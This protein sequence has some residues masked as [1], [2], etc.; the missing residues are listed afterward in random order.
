MVMLW[1]E[2]PSV[3]VDHLEVISQELITFHVFKLTLKIPNKCETLCLQKL[4][5]LTETE[6]FASVEFFTIKKI[7]WLDRAISN[8]FNERSLNHIINDFLQEINLLICLTDCECTLHKNH[9]GDREWN[10]AISCFMLI[11]ETVNYPHQGRCPVKTVELSCKFL[12]LR[13]FIVEHPNTSWW[14]CIKALFDHNWG[15]APKC[16]AI[17]IA[18][19]CLFECPIL[20]FCLCI[21]HQSQHQQTR[22]IS[23]GIKCT[24][25][26]D[27]FSKCNVGCWIHCALDRYTVDYWNSN[28]IRTK[29]VDINSR[30]I[31]IVFTTCPEGAV[32]A[33]RAHRILSIVGEPSHSAFLTEF[34]AAVCDWV[35]WGLACGGDASWDFYGCFRCLRTLIISIYSLKA[36]IFLQMF[37]PW[38]SVHHPDLWSLQRTDQREY[39][40]HGGCGHSCAW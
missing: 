15:G 38:L 18:K 3:N 16:W 9:F 13:M 26:S 12:K 11:N 36:D 27:K 21:V 32:C 5:M 2:D 23:N 28:I 14:W 34:E 6:E 19:N 37:S 40:H 35:I 20:W 22:T 7:K 17:N 30:D 33:W 4:D 24:C 39:P 29:F 31:R 1:L 25:M 8:I 10:K